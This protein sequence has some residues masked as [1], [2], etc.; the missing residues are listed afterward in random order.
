MVLLLSGIVQRWERGANRW[1]DTVSPAPFR[2]NDPLELLDCLLKAIIDDEIVVPSR[3]PNLP[4][5]IQD[6]ALYDVR[7]IE[8]AIIQTLSEFFNSWWQ[9]KYENRSAVGLLEVSCTLTVD[10]KDHVKALGAPPFKR[11]ESGTVT[12]AVDLGPFG[13]L[14]VPHH[15]PKFILGNEEIVLSVL[16]AGAGRTGREADRLPQVGEK[17]NYFLA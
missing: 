2:R 9:D 16:F 17:V 7:C 4:F 11:L 14:A 15:S 1:K 5:G 8:I 3:L 10:I 13:K 12:V 6:A